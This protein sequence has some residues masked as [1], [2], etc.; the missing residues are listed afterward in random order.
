M[1]VKLHTHTGDKSS[2]FYYVKFVVLFRAFLLQIYHQVF[3]KPFAL[4]PP[5]APKNNHGSSHSCSQ[6]IM[7]LFYKSSKL[8]TLYFRTYFT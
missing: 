8:K 2:P 1:S 7:C 3:R 5:L 4:K 6:N